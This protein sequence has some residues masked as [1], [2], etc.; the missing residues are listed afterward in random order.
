MGVR[1]HGTEV[2]EVVRGWS[3]LRSAPPRRIG[4]RH[5][6]RSKSHS[7]QTRIIP[8]FE[9]QE[10]KLQRIPTDLYME[11][12]GNPERHE[13]ELY[14]A[15]ENIVNRPGVSGGHFV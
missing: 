8:F 11:Y 9:S 10:I 6:E 5:D 3:E 12:C 4:E 7:R 13:Y 14:L 1:P 2:A 15:I